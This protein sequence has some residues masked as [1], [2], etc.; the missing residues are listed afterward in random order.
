MLDINPKQKLM[1]LNQACAGLQLAYAWFLEN[2]IVCKVCVCVCLP[3][4]LVITIGV[5]LC[6][7]DPYDCLN[8]F[9]SF[10]MAAKISIISRHGLTYN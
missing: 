7:M 9:Y 6:D 8:K 2:D 4:R 5:M 3:P 1:F 10:C